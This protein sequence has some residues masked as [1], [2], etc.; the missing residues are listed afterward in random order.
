[1]ATSIQVSENLQHE[2]SKK[3]LFERET[4][5][6]VIWDLIE[7]THELSE[8]TKRH[9]AQAERDIKEGRTKP[10]S[11]KFS[12][13]YQQYVDNLL[14]SKNAVFCL[15][16]AIFGNKVILFTPEIWIVLGGWPASQLVF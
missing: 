12:L 16:L 6:E 7:D 3:K 15:C 8:E 14:K 2:L 9:I 5:E 11:E 4:Y 1:M 13:F 10:L